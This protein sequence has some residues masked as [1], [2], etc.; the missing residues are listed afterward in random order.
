MST[1][2]EYIDR[3][4]FW[5]LYDHQCSSQKGW[6]YDSRS[7]AFY[8]VLG[9]SHWTP[10]GAIEKIAELAEAGDELAAKAIRI[11]TIKRLVR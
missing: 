11:A 6:I 5:G 10:V 7:G 1:E 2:P 4:L 3:T 8:I 9:G